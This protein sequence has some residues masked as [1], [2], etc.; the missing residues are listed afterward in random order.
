MTIAIL[1]ICLTIVFCSYFVALWIK[2]KPYNQKP[3]EI[4]TFD[5]EE[6]ENIV[7]WGFHYR[8]GEKP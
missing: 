3:L 5:G 4:K 6:N 8:Y 1:F 2:L 7:F